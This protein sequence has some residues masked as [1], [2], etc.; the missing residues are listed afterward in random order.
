MMSLLRK[1]RIRNKILL[2]LLVPLAGLAFFAVKGTLERSSV[3]GQ[4]EALQRLSHLAVAASALVH[5][6]QKERGMTAGFLGSGGKEFQAEL[7][8]QRRA[9]DGRAAELRGFLKG[10]DTGAFG[11]EFSRLLGAAL[12]KLDPLEDMRRRVSALSVPAPEAIGYYTGLNGA[13]LEVIGSAARLAT[14][15]E[16]G[17]AITAYISFLRAKEAA[18][19]ERAVLTN[20]FA[21]GQFEPGTYE[22]FA[23][24]VAE[25]ATL[26]RMFSALASDTARQDA[27]RKLRHQAVAEAERMRKVAFDRAQAGNFG[28]PAEHW[29][30]T[31]TEKI[32][33]LKDIE[34]AL[35][36]ELGAL[37]G[38]LR[39]GA[40][41][42]QIV[43]LVLAVVLVGGGLMT[44]FLLARSIT[45]PLGDTLAA[46]RDIA[47]GQGDLTRR[48]DA[49]G[50]DEVSE[51]AAAFNRFAEKLHDVIARVREAA[52]LVATASQQ[53][54]GASGQ[55][56][57][58]AQE[59]A[60]SLEETAASLEEITG[61][62]KQNADNAK[63]AN[64]LAIGSRD[65]AD[66]GGQVVKAAVES[67]NEINRA[68]KKIADIITTVDEIAFQTNLLALNAAV[69]AAR[70]GE[71]GRGFAV[72]AAEVRN[73]AQRSAAAAKEIKA[74]IQDSVQKVEAGSELVH[75]SGQTLEEIVTSVK[76]V[77]DMIAEISAASQEQ[78]QGIDQVNKAVTQMDQVTQANA[79]QTEELS[80]TAQALSTQ[81]QQLQRLVARFRLGESAPGA[82]APVPGS[83]GVRRPASPA[84]PAAPP[85]PARHPDHAPEPALAAAGAHNGRGAHDGFEEF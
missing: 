20:T 56:S 69:E 81:A 41:R 54:S 18:G 46:L 26:S 63:Q 27:E 8:A 70:A 15:G 78:S 58:G 49:Q 35:S 32:N 23:A 59:Q 84:R 25:Q 85:R 6:T 77:T 74:L 79:A 80:S 22:R 21:R 60:S 7:P 3:A 73:L 67:M 9:T 37:T 71:Q 82:T 2:L 24:V 34:D 50:Q 39:Q 66:K 45:A 1:I 61:T 5:E 55:L 44:A 68:S 17:R 43:F 62:V 48:L 29:F 16:V 30:R 72:V 11:S 36:R 14:D 12:A 64:Q 65:V 53:L 42:E 52:D 4:M 13:V 83:A 51:I 31:Q 47:E 10:S 38:R 40:R 28:V 75:R 19:I 33:I 57:S 76:R